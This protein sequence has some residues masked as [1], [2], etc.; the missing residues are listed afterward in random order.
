MSHA[1]ARPSDIILDLLRSARSR[2]QSAAALIEAGA[3]F[4]FTENTMRVNLSRLVARGI[5]ESP[6]R[7]V[8]RLS[9]RTDALN[10]FV[11]RWRLGE[12][13]V[14]PWEPGRWL[15]SHGADGAQA[16]REACR[17]ALDALGVRE[18]QPGLLA[19]PENLALDLNALRDLATGIGLAPDVVL[20]SGT[21]QGERM[22]VRW[23]SAWNPAALNADYADA[24]ARLRES[25]RRLTELVPA[26]ARLECFR[27]GGEM[28]HR[29]AKDPLLPAPLVDTEARAALHQAMLAYDRQGKEIWAAVNQQELNQMPRPQLA[30]V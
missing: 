5:L 22:P 9:K 15:V 16:G 19:R 29:L 3:L 7:G 1:R 4:G 21:P 25:A 6:G 11:E 27:L 17:W 26:E 30:T 28:I 20:V 24:V 13:R 10:D 23:L 8:Y 14:Q 18:V 2:R 12:D